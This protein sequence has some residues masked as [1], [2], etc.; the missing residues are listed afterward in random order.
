[1]F[2][3]IESGYSVAVERVETHSTQS[4]THSDRDVD[5]VDELARPL[6]MRQQSAL[7]RREITRCEVEVGEAYPG[8]VDRRHELVDGSIGRDSVVERPPEFDGVE[9]RIARRLGSAQQR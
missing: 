9:T 1:M 8:V 2:G 5:A 3:G 6:R 4:C 7:A